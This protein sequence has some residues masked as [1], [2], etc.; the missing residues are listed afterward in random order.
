MS[1]D[2]QLRGDS[3]RRQAEL[4]KQYAE[5]HQLTLVEEFKLED[6]GI[7]AYRGDNLSAGALGRFV[8]AVKG[9][10]IPKGSYLLVESLD[11]LSRGKI[12]EAMELLLSITNNGVN[13]VTL[14]DQQLYKAYES[15]LEKFIYSIVVMAR[16]NEESE[17]KS[18]RL[19]AAWLQKRRE[20]STKKLTSICPA[21]LSLN[22]TG[23]SFDADTKKVE[24]VK[25]IFDEAAAGKGSDR[26]QCSAVRCPIAP[27]RQCCGV[28]ASPSRSIMRRHPR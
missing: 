13:I 27:A 3:Y 25:R 14:S 26:V 20:A 23:T 11:R 16:A 8:A 4:S 15:T 5:Q 28:R 19:S 21:W 6:I 10:H 7:S 22:S 12:N 9:G 18:R 17:I 1:T 24:L 2:A